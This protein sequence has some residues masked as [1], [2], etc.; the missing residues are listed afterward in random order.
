MLAQCVRR[1]LAEGALVAF[2]ESPEMEE[3]V[4]HGNFGDVANLGR[5]VAQAP[6][7]LLQLALADVGLR[8]G[9][10][11]ALVFASCASCSMEMSCLRC[12]SM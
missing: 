1:Q 4:V 11:L 5:G 8:R 7:D 3:A 9:A 6:M 10:N 2:G 12:S